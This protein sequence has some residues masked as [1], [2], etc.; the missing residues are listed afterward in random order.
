MTNFSWFDLFVITGFYFLF[1]VSVGPPFSSINWSSCSTQLLFK[2]KVADRSIQREP[3]T[4][5]RHL[6]AEL[7]PKV[8]ITAASENVHL[9]DLK[10]SSA[11]LDVSFVLF[12]LC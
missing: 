12:Y 5:S 8:M 3:I 6:H 11:A 9:K 4:V 7:T 1:S 10:F 2:S